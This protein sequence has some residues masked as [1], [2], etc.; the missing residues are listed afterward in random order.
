MLGDLNYQHL[1][2][3]C[4]CLK[5]SKS[6]SEV[7]IV[8]LGSL[9]NPFVLEPEGLDACNF[10]IHQDTTARGQFAAVAFEWRCRYLAGFLLLQCL[11]DFSKEAP[12]IIFA[13]IKSQLGGGQQD[14]RVSKMI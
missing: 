10:Y 3:V 2:T 7:L 12:Q 11:E 5:H 6:R 9:K 8:V 4:L 13:A 14:V 1:L